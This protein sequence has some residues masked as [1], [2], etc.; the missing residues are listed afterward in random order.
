MDAARAGAAK[1]STHGGPGWRRL[2]IE[3]SCAAWSARRTGGSA[4]FRD[5]SVA[6]EP[7]EAVPA[8]AALEQASRAIIDGGFLDQQLVLTGWWPSVYRRSNGPNAPRGLAVP[9]QRAL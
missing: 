8:W 1:S 5:T 4:R 2:G 6:L 9:L 7:T 3:A